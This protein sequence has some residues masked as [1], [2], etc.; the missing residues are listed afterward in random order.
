MWWVAP[1]CVGRGTRLE[2]EHCVLGREG[3]DDVMPLMVMKTLLVRRCRVL[4]P[5]EGGVS[6]RPPA[7]GVATDAQ[8]PGSQQLASW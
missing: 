7:T 2:W 5:S 1:R 6:S 3:P 4:V 8:R